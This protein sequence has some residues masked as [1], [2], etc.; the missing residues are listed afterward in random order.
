MAMTKRQRRESLQNRTED[1]PR[2]RVRTLGEKNIPPGWN[3]LH[4]GSLMG[5][6]KKKKH[7]KRRQN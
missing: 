5:R 3:N 6:E 7:K 2:T 4:K 1:G